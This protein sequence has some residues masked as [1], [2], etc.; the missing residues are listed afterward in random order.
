M[1]D[2]KNFV[3][4]EKEEKDIKRIRDLFESEIPKDLDTDLNLYRWVHGWKGQ[5]NEIEPRLKAYIQNRKLI[6]FDAE[7]YLETFESHPVYQYCFKY[8]SVSL[9]NK[10]YIN[11]KDNTVFFSERWENVD[12]NE[13]VAKVISCGDVTVLTFIIMEALFRHV[14]NQEKRSGKPSGVS[15]VYDMHGCSVLQYANPHH[16]FLKLT[17]ICIDLLQDYYCDILRQIYVINAPT[18]VNVLW[19]LTKVFMSEETRRKIIILGSNYKEVLQKC[20][21]VDILPSH[22]GGNRRDTSGKVHPETCC[23]VPAVIADDYK[24]PSNMCNNFITEYIRPNCL[25]ELRQVVK[26][27]PS[28]LMW[29]FW[30]NSDV[31]F[32][33]VQQISGK[34]IFSG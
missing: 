8:Y 12:F 34:K 5:L 21:D 2:I 14:L 11:S 10:P 19:G 9:V 3:I 24:R 13:I 16:P 6:K 30:V 25:F 26:H 31:E 23:T 4:S 1:E 22:Y 29:K 7:D 15:V 28:T 27:V 32:G 20:F 33:I 17:K 18:V